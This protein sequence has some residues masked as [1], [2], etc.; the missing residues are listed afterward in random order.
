MTSQDPDTIDELVNELDIRYVVL[1][2]DTTTSKF[3]AMSAYTSGKT[4]DYIETYREQDGDLLLPVRIYH[5]SYYQTLG[6]RLYNF[7][8]EAVEPVQTLVVLVEERVNAEGIAFKL[9]LQTR[10]FNNYESAVSFIDAQQSGNYEI[11]G[12]DPFISP[13][14]IEKLNQYTLVYTSDEIV[15]E[16]SGVTNPAVKIF[17]YTG[18]EK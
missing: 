12:V 17:K 14:P 5:P 10:S 3:F 11:I 15:E 1:D 9:V 18:R 16:E 6:V 8:G 7:N 13:V 4:E 2:R